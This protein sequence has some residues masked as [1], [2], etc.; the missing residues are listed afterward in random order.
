MPDPTL[1]KAIDALASGRDLSMEQA[2]DVLRVIMEGNASETQIA[3]STRLKPIAASSETRE[4]REAI[5][6]RVLDLAGIAR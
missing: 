5:L 3:A 2:G 6:D 1:T 4:G